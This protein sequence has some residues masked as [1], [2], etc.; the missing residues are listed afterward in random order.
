[1]CLV[2][3][4]S[5]IVL[6]VEWLTEKANNAMED[7]VTA[8]KRFFLYFTPTAPHV[9]STY[10]YAMGGTEGTPAFADTATPAGTVPTPVSGFTKTRADIKAIADAYNLRQRSRVSADVW[11]DEALGSLMAKMDALEVKD[12]T[13]IIVTMDHVRI[14]G[15]FVGELLMCR[16]QT[17]PS[18]PLP[19]LG[20]LT[21]E[22]AFHAQA[23]FT[24]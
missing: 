18:T 1:V 6:A 19:R 16:L 14:H 7:A 13:L 9:P 24:N 17:R 12:N 20:A 8:G 15:A 10:T 5:P 23:K 22:R 21:S 4:A 2:N 3:P 11:N